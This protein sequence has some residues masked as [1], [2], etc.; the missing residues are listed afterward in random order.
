MGLSTVEAI[1][2]F[3]IILDFMGFK[4]IQTVAKL[5]RPKE[6]DHFIIETSKLKTNT[7]FQEIHSGINLDLRHGDILV[8]KDIAAA[9]ISLIEHDEF[10]IQKNIFEKCSKVTSLLAQN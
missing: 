4:S 2:K 6:L 3:Q 5:Q 9:S 8:L 10:N 7:Q 1:E